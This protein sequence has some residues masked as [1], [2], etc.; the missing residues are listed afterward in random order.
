MHQL[1]AWNIGTTGSITD[2]ADMSNTSG[3]MTLMA[4]SIVARC[5]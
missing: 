3:A 4:W 5:S 2:R 1:L